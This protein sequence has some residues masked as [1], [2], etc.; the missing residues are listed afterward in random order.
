MMDTTVGRLG[1]MTGRSKGTPPL[2]EPEFY[3][4]LC[5]AAPL[6]DLMVLVFHPEGVARDG[7]SVQG[8]T[9]SKGLWREAS[10]SPPDIL[11]NRCLPGSPQEKRTAASAQAL[12]SRSI[13]WSRGLPDKWGVYEI[14]RRHHIASQLLPDTRLYT[15]TRDMEFMLS[16]R[17]S[18]VFLK[19]RTGS[20]GKGTFHAIRLAGVGGGLSVR[21]RDRNNA[22]FQHVFTTLRE[23]LEWIHDLIGTR[24]YIM[25]PYLHLTG[26]G[27]RSFDV[28][29][30]MQKNGHGAWTL[31][32]MAVRLGG[33]GSLTSNLHGGGTAVQPLPFLLAEY[34]NYGKELLKELAA[35]SALLPPLLEQ[36]CG[37]LGELGLDFGLDTEGRI[38]LLEV[39]S[40]PG[41]TVFRLTGDRRAAK[42][43]AEN[44]LSYARHLLRVSTGKPQ[45]ALRRA[46]ILK[47]E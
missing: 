36:S 8:Y 25:Q 30:L 34:G 26:S 19:P 13:A 33:P 20:H 37:R 38:Y 15:G 46:P 41:R 24:R 18:G 3:S 47:G 9:W 5:Q 32:G 45:A 21:G 39:N 14:L 27:D 23:G 31:T 28:R 16:E 6:Y 4:H 12:L 35:A 42:L 29:A 22:S 17:D 40:K 1:I 7:Q 43:A 2:T 44:P 10:G 11:Y